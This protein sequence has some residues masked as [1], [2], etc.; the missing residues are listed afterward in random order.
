MS[1]LITIPGDDDVNLDDGNG[2]GA[3]AGTGR[4][5]NRRRNTQFDPVDEN[6]DDIQSIDVMDFL[7]S[8]NQ[9]DTVA[10]VFLKDTSERKK[11]FW[12]ILSK[13]SATSKL[14]SD[15]VETNRES[16]PVNGVTSINILK[17][18]SNIYDNNYSIINQQ[19]PIQG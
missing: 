7:Q 10:S 12:Q 14:I 4:R 16:I 5:R 11:N 2:G 6:H 18:A 19:Q 9:T 13:Q 3:N 8:L 17:L 15:A 1:S